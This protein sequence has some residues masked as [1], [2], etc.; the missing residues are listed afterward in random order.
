MLP[1]GPQPTAA[2]LCADSVLGL[3]VHNE[4]ESTGEVSFDGGH[5]LNSIHSM[6][7]AGQLS[8]VAASQP[9]DCPTREKHGW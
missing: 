1:R 8:N 7:R 2:Q 6:V 3:E 5:I 4:L 9:T